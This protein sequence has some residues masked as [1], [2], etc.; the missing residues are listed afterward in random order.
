MM[1]RLQQFSPYHITHTLNKME[2]RGNLGAQMDLFL[3]R[4][5]RTLSPD[6]QNTMLDLVANEV[7]RKKKVLIDVTPTNRRFN[8]NFFCGGG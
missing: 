1:E 2:R 4:P 5:Y 3:Q 8:R 6:S 7:S